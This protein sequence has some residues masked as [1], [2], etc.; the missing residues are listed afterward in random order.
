[1]VTGY[2]LYI[3]TIVRYLATRISH[4]FTLLDLQTLNEQNYAIWKANTYAVSFI[5]NVIWHFK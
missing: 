5:I 2:T 4:R 3:A 1:M